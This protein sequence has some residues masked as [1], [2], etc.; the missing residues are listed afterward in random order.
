M[1][2]PT[3]ET[4]EVGKV[5][6][7]CVIFRHEKPCS[8]T[9]Q[10]LA[11]EV[12]KN[13]S[14]LAGLYKSLTDEEFLKL[15]NGPMR[16]PGVAFLNSTDET[17]LLG[18]ICQE[19]LEDLNQ[20][21]SIVSRLGK[22]CTD[23]ELIKFETTYRKMKQGAVD[24]S[25]L[26][27]NSRHVGKIIEKMEEY[28]SNTSLLHSSL[29]ALNELESLEKK[30]KRGKT[31]DCPQVP[32]DKT[33]VDLYNDKISFQRKQIRHFR[34]VSL[35]S[36]TFDKCVGLMA[37]IVFTVYARICV[38]FGPF[39]PGLVCTMFTITTKNYFRRLHV[40]HSKAFHMKVYPEAEYCLFVKEENHRRKA[41]KSCPIL[42]AS[43]FKRGPTTPF[44]SNEISPEAKGLGFLLSGVTDTKN[45][46][47]ANTRRNQRLIQ[48]APENTVG[49][50]GL[51]L[52]YANLIIMAESYFYSTAIISDD[53]RNLMFEMLPAHMKQ[54]LRGKLRNHWY[55]DAKEREDK[56]L[57]EW[58]K[59]ALEEI[60]EWLAPV[61]HDTLRW[62]QDRNLEQ[63]NLNAM[64]SV[65]LFQT[66]HFSDLEKTEAAIVEVLVGLS[67]IYRYENRRER[68]GVGYKELNVTL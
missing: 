10:I 38:I 19:K 31:G 44:L 51:A 57:A 35:W 63:Q 16:S 25:N 22:N 40:S 28:A 33:N 49:A 41:S 52:H 37:R 14:R 58:W 68:N 46:V 39:V 4:G 62:Q 56:V 12:A 43:R 1:A 59:K 42:K 23:E 21:A 26:D 17:F 32:S 29:V 67:C 27:F 53:E 54:I 48:S 36:K 61:A 45:N 47:E 60:I 34:Q 50:T 20:I 65:L 7:G 15:R 8:P 18:L 13:M 64:P 5:S 6:Y 66:L 55:K 30:M 2:W 3:A 9:L 11:F 24:V